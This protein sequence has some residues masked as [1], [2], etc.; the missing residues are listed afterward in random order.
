MVFPSSLHEW[1]STDMIFRDTDERLEGVYPSLLQWLR[2]NQATTTDG[3]LNVSLGPNGAFFAWSTG[4]CRWANVPAAF[5]TDIQNMLCHDGWKRRPKGVTFGINES[6]VIVCDDGSWCPNGLEE[7][8]PGLTELLTHS[9]KMKVCHSQIY[10]C[11]G[12]KR[13]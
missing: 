13:C 11:R 1:H 8:Y 7:N 6:Y 12:W 10:H 4:S 2:E 5:Q 3:S 9:G